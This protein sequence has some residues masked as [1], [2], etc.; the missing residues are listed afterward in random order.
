VKRRSPCPCKSNFFGLTQEYRFLLFKQIHEIVF[1]G[2][3][4]YDYDT[5][6]NMPVWLRKL[7]FNL[8]QNSIDQENKQQK[9]NYEKSLGKTGKTTLDW[10]NPD[11]SKLQ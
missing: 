1:Y 4:G 10:A 5:V 8:I 7:T 11:K 2:R 9:E 3:G 6:Y